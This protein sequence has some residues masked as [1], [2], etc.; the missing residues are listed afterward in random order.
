MTAQRTS[1]RRTVAARGEGARL[2]EEILDAAIALC[3]ELDDPWKL[4]LRA[5][6]RKVGITPTSIYLHFDSIDALLMAVKQKLWRE[7]GASMIASA[8]ESGPTPYEQVIGFG[9]AYVSFA[10]QHPGAFRQLF[11]K[12][13][14][15][16]LID[17]HS[18]VGEAQ[19]DLLVDALADV[20]SSKEDAR[21][22]ATQLWCGIHGLVVLRTPMSHF[23]WPDID[24]QLRSMA[25]AWTT[26]A[27]G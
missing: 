17:G 15:L 6:A 21:L 14:N 2:R 23:A 24:E 27:A 8:E 19:F 16:P 11:T 7:F 25:R 13:W 12:T 22:R 1:R 20:S 18:F 10:Q 4:S 5:V 3:E 26:P 9:R